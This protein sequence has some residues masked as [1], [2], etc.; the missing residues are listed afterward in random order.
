MPAVYLKN[1]RIFDLN[2]KPFVNLILDNL[3]NNFVIDVENK[4]IIIFVVDAKY[5][6]IS[7]DRS[8]IQ[9]IN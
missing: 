8:N 5:N 2:G 7:Y 3:T 9:E 4:R 1:I 6:M